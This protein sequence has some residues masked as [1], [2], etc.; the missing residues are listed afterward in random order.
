MYKVLL[1]EDEE[2]IRR[3]LRYTFDWLAADCI[4]VG[5]A[6]NGEEGLASMGALRPDIII[7]DVNMPLMDGITMIEQS[8][9]QGLQPCSYIILSGYDE[10]RIA[11]QAI[12]L[13]VSEYLLKPLEQEQLSSALER[14]KQQV[15]MRVQYEALMHHAAA[16]GEE[17]LKPLVQFPDKA[18]RYVGKMLQYIQ[19]S[20]AEKISI[21]DLV[22]QLQVSAT[23]LNRVFKS[24]TTYT[25]HDFLNR[26]R[27][28]QAMDRLKSGEDKIYT[29]AEEVGFSDYKYFITIFKKYAQCTPGQYQEQFGRSVN[30]ASQLT[31]SV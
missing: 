10:F 12:G 19:S 9:L 27:I 5:E 30:S 7:V 18:S 25:F 4:V 26:F 14:A 1:V 3:G 15:N 2:M 16:S 24:E 11:K 17:R 22:E 20:Y 6:E 8:Q 28:Q 13:G 21:Q 23:Y 31:G 29:I